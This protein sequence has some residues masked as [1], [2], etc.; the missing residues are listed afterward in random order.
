MIKRSSSQALLA[1][2][3]LLAGVAGPH[4]A[5]AQPPSDAD[6]ASPPAGVENARRAW[7]NW[8][9][10]CQGC[11]R[12]DG[13]GSEGTA[14]SLAGTVAKFLWVPGGREYLIRVP[15]VATSPLSSEDLAEV[16]NWMLWRFDREHVPAGFQPFTAAEIARGRTQPLRLEASQMRG[17]LLAKAESSG[18]P[19][20]PPAK[21]S[22]PP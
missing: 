9:L 4:G 8:T 14:P 6:G 7:Q 11:H 17:E 1:A 13:T 12:P 22:H 10:N 3:L 5:G 16:V 2:A 18:P 15:G 21:E 20:G 19:G